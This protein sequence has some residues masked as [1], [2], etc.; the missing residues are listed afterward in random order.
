VMFDGADQKPAIEIH[1]EDASDDDTPP[2]LRRQQVLTKLT[3][4][5]P[6]GA[7]EFLL[8]LDPECPMAVVMVV[9]KDEQPSRRMQVVLAGEYSRPVSVAPLVR[10][11]P[12]AAGEEAAP[13]PEQGSET[14]DGAAGR[15]ASNPG[16]AALRAGW[17]GFFR[18]GG[19]PVA[20]L[21]AV[22]LLNPERRDQLLQGIAL[23]AA[24]SLALS[25]VAWASLSPPSWGASVWMI[26]VAA[27]AL[28]VFF[29]DRAR[30]WRWAAV[31]V[32]GFFCGLEIA[33][34]GGFFSQ[35]HVREFRASEVVA[36]VAG[37][38]I[39]LVL[40]GLVVVGVLA[41]LGRLPRYRV[42]VV[43]PLVAVTAGY[44]LF[45]LVEVFL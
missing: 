31:L 21:V 4:A 35:I 42:L 11:D 1:L 12:F 36:F 16:A 43:Q 3:G 30:W 20:L 25:L 32:A 14:T 15:R 9:I 38:E 2:E 39:A 5:I 41:L 29:T 23:L 44:A 19:L 18:L 8:Y 33:R 22:L 6:E 26:V 28:E 40:S 34:A 24:Q 37:A 17:S 27:L 13:G 10:G 45:C 7:K